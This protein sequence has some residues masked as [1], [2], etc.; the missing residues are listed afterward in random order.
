MTRSRH[1]RS[2]A[3]QET[4]RALS[5]EGTSAVKLY[6]CPACGSTDVQLSFPVWVAANDIDDQRCWELDVEAQPEKE[7]DKGWCPRCESNVLVSRTG[8]SRETQLEITCEGLLRD[9]EEVLERQ[10]EE[11]WDE[12]VTS[13]THYRKLGEQLLGR[14]PYKPLPDI[15]TGE[16]S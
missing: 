3:E 16:G 5:A 12:T 4:T 11:W 9:I 14:E 1:E 7:S 13:G 10:G 15:A 2:Q 6:A 8:L